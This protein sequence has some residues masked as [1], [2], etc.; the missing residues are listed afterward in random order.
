VEPRYLDAGANPPAGVALYYYLREQAETP[1]TLEI[2]SSDGTL[3]RRISENVPSQA[4]LNRYLWNMRLPGAPLVEDKSIDPWRREDGP[5]VLPGT[6]HARLTVGDRELKQEF[7]ITPDRRPGASASA[8]DLRAQFDLLCEILAKIGT[9]NELVN[10]ID[11]LRSQLSAWVERGDVVRQPAET[12]RTTLDAL[13]GRLI[14][15]H[16]PEAQLHAMGIQEKLNALF[17]FV[18]STDAAPPRQG[19]DVFTEL[20]ARLDAAVTEFDQQIRPQ[21]VALNAAIRN[22]GLD[23][24]EVK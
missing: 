20:S 3:L 22:A 24:V 1:V 6:Y 13:R 19:R 18:D 9:A 21:V 8:G 15:V 11:S 2:T 23:F 17:E 5:L 12:L 10:R 16:Y 4:G 14:D 7:E